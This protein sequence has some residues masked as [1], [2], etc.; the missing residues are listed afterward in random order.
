METIRFAIVGMGNQGS[1]YAN[2]ITGRPHPG[3]PPIPRP[4]N[5]TLTAVCDSRPNDLDIASELGVRGF[6]DWKAMIASGCCDAVILT[7]PHFL[8][9]EIGIFALKHHV[10]VLCEKP[11]G[12]RASD[13]RQLLQTRDETGGALAMMFQQRTN[14]LFHSLKTLLDSGELGRLRRCNWIVNHY[15]RPDSYYVSGAWRGTWQGEGGG[16]LVNQLPHYL[17]LW[18]YLCGKPRQL[19]ACNRTGAHRNIQ[20]ENDVTVLAEYPDGAT[21][22]F[23]A[24][25]HEPMGTDRLELDLDQGKI[26]VENSNQAT[27]FRFAQSEDQWNQS[28]S[29]PQMQ[30]LQQEPERHHDTQIITSQVPFGEGYSRLIT[31]FA[32]HILNGTPLI[33]TGEDGLAQVELA[34]AIYLSGWTRQAVQLPCVDSEYDTLLTMH[35]AQEQTLEEGRKTK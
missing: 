8:H 33:A 20:V 13:V 28:L 21:G 25:T 23:V 6:T 5:C 18:L 9:H 26:I 3:K 2:I 15:W 7:V 4:E 34:N 35:M 29:F 11:A 17:D 12:V 32:A 10:H 30:H 19:Y 27:I 16:L 22:V 14:P 31:N 1:L 24:C